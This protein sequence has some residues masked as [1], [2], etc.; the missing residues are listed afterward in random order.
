MT[1]IPCTKRQEVWTELYAIYVELYIRENMRPVSRKPETMLKTAN[2]AAQTCLAR[3][4][5]ARNSPKSF[6]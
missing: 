5:S 4:V 1:P 2:M 6:I 3:R